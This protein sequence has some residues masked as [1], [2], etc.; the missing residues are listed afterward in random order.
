MPAT[1]EKEGFQDGKTFRLPTSLSVSPI[2]SMFERYLKDFI[3]LW[4]QWTFAQAIQFQLA[5]QP[6]THFL[7]LCLG[8]RIPQRFL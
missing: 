5:H 7:K 1:P 4:I 6:L 3:L 2:I 8:G